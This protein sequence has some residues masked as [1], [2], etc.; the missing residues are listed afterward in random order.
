MEKQF[1][2]VNNIESGNYVGYVWYSDADKPELINGSFDKELL[3]QNPFIIEGQLYDEERQVSYSI[4]FVDGEYWIMQYNLSE[5]QDV[6]NAELSFFANR[7][8]N[9][10]LK[11]RQYWRTQKDENCEGFE[12]LHPAEYVFIGFENINNKE[13]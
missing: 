8:P 1:M 12:V 7:I 2:K 11:F 3:V 4:K 5:M 9:K 6:E 13:E 10:K